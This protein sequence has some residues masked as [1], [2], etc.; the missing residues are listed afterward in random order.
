M[1]Q[2]IG[3]LNVTPDSF[4]DGGKYDSTEAALVQ[5]R[6]LLADGATWVDVGAE[7]TRPNAETITVETE[8]E[9][10]KAFWQAVLDSKDLEIEKFSLDTRNPSTAQKFLAL[11]GGIIN[12][13]SGFQD[14]SMIDLAVK[15]QATCL[16]NH[17]PG[18]SVEEV[19]EQ[20]IS[21]IEVVKADLLVKAAE[22]IE[23]GVARDKIILDP[24]IGF[25]KTLTL[26]EAL[27]D[28]SAHVPSWP[29]LIGH[30]KKRFLGD[31]RYE[32]DVNVAA[33]ERAAKAGAAYVRVHDP[34]WYK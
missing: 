6:Q 14:P 23:R 28:F 31:D 21:S 20:N 4:S 10:M 22:M 34:Q 3:I 25:G 29:V 32:K 11:G 16:V 12:D 8:W 19:H 13:V 15:Y 9:R 26:N 1:T 2:L 33:G 27:L 5:A 30:S 18:K 17:F 24:G 7:S